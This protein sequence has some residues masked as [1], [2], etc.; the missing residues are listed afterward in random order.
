MNGMN[1]LSLAF[2]APQ[3]PGIPA[4]SFLPYN[5]PPKPSQG[6]CL[7]TKSRIFVDIKYA[8]CYYFVS[9]SFFVYFPGPQDS[10][11][12]SVLNGRGGTVAPAP[13][14]PRAATIESVFLPLQVIGSFDIKTSLKIKYK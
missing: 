9:R 2:Q 14:Q 7:T 1:V 3:I 13:L 10:F 4:P 5:S 8:L 11:A 6:K 12:G